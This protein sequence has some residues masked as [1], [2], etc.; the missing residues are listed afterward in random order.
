VYNLYIVQPRLCYICSRNR[1]SKI[2]HDVTATEG[3]LPFAVTTDKY[4]LIDRLYRSYTMNDKLT[5]F[6]NIEFPSLQRLSRETCR[7]ETR[8]HRIW[9]FLFEMMEPYSSPRNFPNF[10]G[11]L[12][13]ELQRRVNRSAAYNRMNITSKQHL[14]KKIWFHFYNLRVNLYQIIM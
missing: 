9:N 2:L 12:K 3:L 13:K 8:P 4:H 11:E 14:I 1:D 10:V 6:V 5:F 7:I